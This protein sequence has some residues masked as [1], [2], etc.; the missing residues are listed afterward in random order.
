MIHGKKLPNWLIVTCVHLLLFVY[1]SSLKLKFWKCQNFKVFTLLPF[2]ICFFL[3]LPLWNPL[4]RPPPPP[5]FYLT[6]PTGWKHSRLAPLTGF[7]LRPIILP[8]ADELCFFRIVECSLTK[9][10]WW[11]QMCLNKCMDKSLDKCMN[12]ICCVY[13]GR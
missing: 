5:F 9:H 3:S 12:K 11:R 7:K 4:F 13:L 1:D 8:F 2:H 6:P 10:L